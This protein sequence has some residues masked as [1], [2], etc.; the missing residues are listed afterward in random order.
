MIDKHPLYFAMHV[1]EFDKFIVHDEPAPENVA[2]EAE[3]AGAAAAPE[4][5][6]AGAA[7]VPETANVGAGAA[8]NVGAAASGDENRTKPPLESSQRFEVNTVV[9][10]SYLRRI[11]DI[12]SSYGTVVRD[13]ESEAKTR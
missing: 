5:E 7:A 9:W 3:V 4:P 2:P 10:F 8:A 6:V 1:P 12:C 13:F 11:Y